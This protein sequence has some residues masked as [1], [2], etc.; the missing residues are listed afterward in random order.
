MIPEC[1]RRCKC[2]LIPTRLTEFLR[3]VS[4][5]TQE[6]NSECLPYN[7]V[8]L[9]VQKSGINAKVNGLSKKSNGRKRVFSTTE[10]YGSYDKQSFRMFPAS[11][12]NTKDS[13]TSSCAK[14]GSPIS[15][16][17][18]MNQQEPKSIYLMKLRQMIKD[19]G[20]DNIRIS[21]LKD[22]IVEISLDQ[23]GSRYIQK[24]YETC[25]AEEK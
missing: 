10:G 13:S 7:G 25:S 22:H 3:T 18:S 12:S 2:I 1:H 20:E 11:I 17:V 9:P 23:I 15:K 5:T 19:S 21:E 8:H 14:Y 6:N 16:Q 24:V 4:H